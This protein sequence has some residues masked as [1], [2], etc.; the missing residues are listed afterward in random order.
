LIKCGSDDGIK[1][2][3]NGKTIHDNN[4]W[5]GVTVDED[6]VK[7][8][9]RKGMNSLLV[10]VNNGTGGFGFCI[11]ITTPANTTL[12]NIKLKLPNSF[13][14]DEIFKSIYSSFN[15]YTTYDKTD[16]SPKFLTRITSESCIP[17]DFMGG[18]ILKLSLTENSGKV[19]EEFYSE[20]LDNI[21]NFKTKELICKPNN[22][23]TGRYVIK[24][25][26]MDPTGNILT[27]KD[28]IVFWN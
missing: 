20:K 26:I 16:G 19:I 22:L 15:I 3:L 5:R 6:I 12:E 14:F 1:I 27:E 9:L 23:T 28:D 17:V 7:S 13:S 4:V 11:R 24:L 21:G 25:K 10:K 18:L 8:E 2:I